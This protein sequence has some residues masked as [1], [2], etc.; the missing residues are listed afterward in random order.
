MIIQY[1]VQNENHSVKQAENTETFELQVN[2]AHLNYDE[3]LII[4]KAAHEEKLQP[5]ESFEILSIS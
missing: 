1:C 3:A 4:V 5:Y 2:A